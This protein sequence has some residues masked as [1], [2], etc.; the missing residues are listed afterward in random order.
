MI[1]NTPQ[2]NSASIMYARYN[3]VHEKA[4]RAAASF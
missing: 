1:G 4:G 2:P 3:E